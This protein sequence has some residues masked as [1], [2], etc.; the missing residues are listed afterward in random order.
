MKGKKRLPRIAW[1]VS[2][3]LFLGAGFF[4][5]SVLA[6]DALVASQMVEKARLTFQAFVGDPNMAAFVGLI[7]K[8][9]GVLISP[10][11]LKGAF[12]IGASGGSGVFLARQSASDPWA[13]PA[14]YTVGEVSFGLQI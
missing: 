5:S 12:V 11:V 2:I 9:R 4:H 1:G 8:A 7:K 14:F 6:D 13:G 10:Q 3:L